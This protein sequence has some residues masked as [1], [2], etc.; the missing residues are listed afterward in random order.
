MHPSLW[1]ATDFRGRRW[2]GIAH[3]SAGMRAGL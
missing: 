1:L 2:W 3:A